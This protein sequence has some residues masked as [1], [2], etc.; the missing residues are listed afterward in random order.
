M[1][2]FMVNSMTGHAPPHTPIARLRPGNHP[3]ERT[4]PTA[5]GRGDQ[6]GPSAPPGPGQ[7]TGS[8]EFRWPPA[9]PAASAKLVRRSAAWQVD[10]ALLVR[11]CAPARRRLGRSRA[12]PTYPVASPPLPVG[13]APLTAPPALPLPAGAAP[14][15]PPSPLSLPAGAAPRAPPSPL[16]L[17]AGAGSSGAAIA[18][19]SPGWSGS[20]GAASTAAGSA[21]FFRGAGTGTGPCRAPAAPTRGVGTGAVAGCVLVGR[22]PGAGTGACTDWISSTPAPLGSAGGGGGG[23]GQDRISAAR[24]SILCRWRSVW[25]CSSSRLRRH[26]AACSCCVAAS[27]ATILASSSLCWPTPGSAVPPVLGFGTTVNIHGRPSGILMLFI[28][29]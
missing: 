21:A 12:P 20:S 2:E 19:V 16:S 3:A 27:S 10:A 17:P 25:S 7:A 11:S 29:T 23:V 6:P 15:A 26:T 5:S 18:A 14:W 9:N 1:E 8:C 13:A 4:P 22:N 24:F 28:N